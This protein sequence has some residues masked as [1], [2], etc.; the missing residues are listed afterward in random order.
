MC[1]VPIV[2]HAIHLWHETGTSTWPSFPCNPETHP[3]IKLLLSQ[4]WGCFE[5]ALLRNINYAKQSRDGNT[6]VNSCM[7]AKTCVQSEKMLLLPCT[8]H[9][10]SRYRRILRCVWLSKVTTPDAS[11]DS[12]AAQL[13]SGS[14]KKQL[15]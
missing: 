13:T 3:S 8:T 5:L 6:E 11:V 14:S 4:M 12:P 9:T 10:C 7:H 2:V 15:V 1:A